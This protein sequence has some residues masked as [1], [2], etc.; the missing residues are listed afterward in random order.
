MHNHTTSVAISGKKH[1]SRFMLIDVADLPLLGSGNVNIGSHGYPV[2]TRIKIKHLVHRLIMTPS[3]EQVVDHINGDR[4]DNRR[5][6]LRLC[7]TAQNARNVGR[8][9]ASL[10]K[11]VHWDKSRSCYRVWLD[12]NFKTVFLGSFADPLFGAEVYDAACA[13]HHGDFS[14]PNFAGGI[15][16][17][18]AAYLKEWFGP[19]W[20]VTSPTEEVFEL[21]SLSVFCR[22]R[23]L[24]ANSMTLLAAGKRH[25]HKGWRCERISTLPTRAEVA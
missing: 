3:P 22:E 10:Y 18:A 21:Q 1:A 5:E 19:R 20:R 11:G 17:R 23:Q 2:I 16:V 4:L 7:T 14:R 13:E 6:N 9:P 8:R 12:I 25:Y 15:T 24:I